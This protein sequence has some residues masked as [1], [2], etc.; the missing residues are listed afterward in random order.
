MKNHR[1]YY[2]VHILVPI[3]I[4]FFYDSIFIL[5]FGNSYVYKIGK[6]WQKLYELLECK[7]SV[8]LFMYHFIFYQSQITMCMIVF[9]FKL[10][11]VFYKE[12][13]KTWYILIGGT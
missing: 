7:L 1:A 5:F 8:P 9:H 12:I 2:L 3:I 11:L 13:I 10:Q 4:S 6:L